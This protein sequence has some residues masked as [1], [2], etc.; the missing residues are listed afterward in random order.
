M[1]REAV[2]R[3]HQKAIKA[4]SVVH[5]VSAVLEATIFLQRSMIGDFRTT[6]RS[7]SLGHWPTLCCENVNLSQLGSYL[8]R[9][10]FLPRHSTFLHQA[11]KPYFREDHFS[12]GRPQ[13]GAAGLPINTY[14][15]TSG[16]S[17]AVTHHLPR[18]ISS[19]RALARTACR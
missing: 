15:A 1:T 18:A 6:Y 8:F 10:V 9:L 17:S 11:Q 5:F 14:P 3:C 16:P 13:T 2:W 12:G 7:H 4:G 19:Q